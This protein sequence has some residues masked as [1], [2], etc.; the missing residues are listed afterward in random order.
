MSDKQ[1]FLLLRLFTLFFLRFPGQ[2]VQA[3]RPA[4][5]EDAGDAPCAHPARARAA[6]A[7]AA[8]PDA[9][10][11]GPKVCPEGID[12]EANERKDGISIDTC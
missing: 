5:E 9:Q 4:P 6:H 10:V 8:E 1:F 12:R 7:Q 3:A 2:K 11:P